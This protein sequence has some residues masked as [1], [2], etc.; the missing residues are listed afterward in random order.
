[1]LLRKKINFLISKHLYEHLSL[2]R[3]NFASPIIGEPENK[4]KKFQKYS[5]K[6][7]NFDKT[8]YYLKDILLKLSEFQQNSN[9]T[10]EKEKELIIYIKE[11]LGYLAISRE[12]PL[13]STTNLQKSIK[14]TL[15]SLKSLE[16][17][18]NILPTIIRNYMDVFGKVEEDLLKL[19]SKVIRNAG[20][21]NEFALMS[22]FI[23]YSKTNFQDKEI[24]N[25][26]ASLLLKYES[27]DFDAFS[28]DTLLS[29]F[30]SYSSQ[31]KINEEIPKKLFLVL[32]KRSGKFTAK[33]MAI[34]LQNISK[35]PHEFE[36]IEKLQA[37]LIIQ[38][39]AKEKEIK[40]RDLTMIAFNFVK[41]IENPNIILIKLMLERI[42]STQKQYV[43]TQDVVLTLSFLIKLQTK[44]KEFV[45]DIKND[46]NKIV[47]GFLPMIDKMLTG[48]KI[49][50]QDLLGIF[51]FLIKTTTK[52]DEKSLEIYF[53]HYLNTRD[54]E[55]CM[56][57]GFFIMNF[58]KK[59]S[60]VFNKFKDG[61]I[62]NILAEKIKINYENIGA[63]SL[64]FSEE[65]P[66]IVNFFITKCKKY[67]KEQELSYKEYQYIFAFL[68]KKELLAENLKPISEVL[69]NIM[70]KMENNAYKNDGI[71]ENLLKIVNLAL[72]MNNKDQ[73]VI[74]KISDEII[75]N[76][77]CKKIQK[78]IKPF[79]LFDFIKGLLYIENSKENI[80]K[81]VL[82]IKECL[83][84]KGISKEKLMDE[85]KLYLMKNT[86][87]QT[88]YDLENLPLK[89]IIEKI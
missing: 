87:E 69:L 70:K 80:D 84:S 72:K 46:I 49:K 71:G 22:S 78:K 38:F 82:V 34:F 52:I 57:F 11:S 65:K 53:Q 21:L 19:L 58:Q 23:V 68:E 61:L 40:P 31:I 79:D 7:K 30:A 13:S 33:N 45:N 1:M 43:F 81:I 85:F 17:F 47:E 51:Y 54:N 3:Y 9:I 24:W 32:L 48:K 67:L 83:E 5:P 62:N 73:A 12:S 25:F 63:I 55:N 60:I 41:I 74:N 35:F 77:Q 76:I 44:G 37:I 28:T 20:Y 8:P 75:R 29:I 10:I 42:E 4:P 56:F 88:I 50:S 64:A 39:S 26:L 86:E 2:T 89:K 6:Q 36:N 16:K 66:D 18:P 59:Y 14:Y 27:T 15:L